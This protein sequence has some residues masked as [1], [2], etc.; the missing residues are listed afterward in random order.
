LASRLA[1]AA[2]AVLGLGVVLLRRGLQALVAIAR[3]IAVRLR[4]VLIDQVLR[5]ARHV[6]N[7]EI[8]EHIALLARPARASA[9]AHA[10]RRDPVGEIA[11]RHDG[12]LVDQ[13]HFAAGARSPAISAEGDR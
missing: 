10:L 2:V 13:F 11:Q 8:L 4:L 12:A 6:R 7:A 3:T 9:S 1:L 5:Q